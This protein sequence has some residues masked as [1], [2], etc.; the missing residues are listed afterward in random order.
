MEIGS[1]MC[2]NIEGILYKCRVLAIDGEMATVGDVDGIEQSVQITAIVDLQ[3]GCNR[4][5]P[6]PHLVCA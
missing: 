3:P 1:E 6:R 4:P 2:V 5:F